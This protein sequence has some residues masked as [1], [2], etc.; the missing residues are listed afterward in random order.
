MKKGGYIMQFQKSLSLS[1]ISPKCLAELFSCHKKLAK[2]MCKDIEKTSK[3]SISYNKEDSSNGELKVSLFLYKDTFLVKKM[4][5]WFKQNAKNALQIHFYE[6]ENGVVTRE[7][8]A[9][10]EDCY[11]N[12]YDV[13]GRVLV[14]FYKKGTIL[15]MYEYN[16]NGILIK[17]NYAVNGKLKR[18][19]NFKLNEYNEAFHIIETDE[20]GRKIMSYQNVPKSNYM[21]SERLETE[22]NE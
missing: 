7:T 9:N 8:F 11:V 19:F 21:R 2:Q 14:R 10:N 18:I 12:Q 13:D 5:Y 16:D 6:I 22:I 17:M 15:E 4:D 3:D 1:E 20:Y